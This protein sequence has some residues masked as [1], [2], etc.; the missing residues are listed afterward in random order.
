MT[1]MSINLVGGRL[2]GGRYLA[3]VNKKGRRQGTGR[4]RSQAG[5][6]RARGGHRER[7]LMEGTDQERDLVEGTDWERE[8]EGSVRKDTQLAE[9][10]GRESLR[11]T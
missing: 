3:K 7:E 5:L 6:E 10:T 2:V 1:I 8:L 4:E 11:E 9:G